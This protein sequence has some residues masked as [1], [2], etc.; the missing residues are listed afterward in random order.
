MRCSEGEGNGDNK[1]KRRRRK[2]REERKE[3]E[4][5][6]GGEEEEK[7][8]E[9]DEDDEDDDKDDRPPSLLWLMK[10]SVCLMAKRE[11]AHTPKVHV[12]RTSVFKFL[13]AMA[14][15]LGEDRL[16]PYLTTIIS[17]LY[18]ELDSTYA[19][20]DPT[21][22]NLAQELIELMKRK[23]GLGKFSLAFSAVQ[24]EFTQRR[25]ARK[26]HRA[27]QAVA[28]PDIAAKKKIKKHKNKIEAKKRK[29]EFL[30]TTRIQGQ[31][32][33]EPRAPRPGYFAVSPRTPLHGAGRR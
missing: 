3:K 20:Q 9:E 1:R 19:E 25:V 2:K 18:R 27:M 32:A 4:E 13:G 10:N 14:M 8:E 30:P 15:D 24:K 28:N 12:K 22:K 21:L 11:A 23:V 5:K 7:E 31:E 6:R 29:I 26:R 17:P 16:G 33:P